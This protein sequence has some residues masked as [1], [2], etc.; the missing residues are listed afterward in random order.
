VA[1][2][3]SLDRMVSRARSRAIARLRATLHGPLPSQRS[4]ELARL[5]LF[6]Q[7]ATAGLAETADASLDVRLAASPEAGPRQD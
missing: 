6:G 3:S 7:S 5:R 2:G 1:A 4:V